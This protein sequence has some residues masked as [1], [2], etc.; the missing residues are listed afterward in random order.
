MKKVLGLL[1][2]TLIISGLAG[3]YQTTCHP[4]AGNSYG[5]PHEN[6]DMKGEG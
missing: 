3:C 6:A 2:L 4:P 1:T 5:N